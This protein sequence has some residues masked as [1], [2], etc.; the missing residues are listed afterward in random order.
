MDTRDEP[1]PKFVASEG[2]IAALQWRF[3]PDIVK[4]FT[5]KLETR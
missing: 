4:Y 1:Q 5:S 3:G 2:E